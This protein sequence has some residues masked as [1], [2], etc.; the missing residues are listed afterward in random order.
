MGDPDDIGGIETVT[1]MPAVP[2]TP[3]FQDLLYSVKG[4]VA[5]I[6]MNR[7]HRRNALSGRLVNE[8]IVALEAAGADAGVG[9][10]VLQGAGGAF[11][12]GGDLSQMVG[13]G[14]DPLGDVPVRGGFVELNLAFTKVGKPIV[15]KVHRYAYGGGLGLVCAAH[16]AIAEDTAK[17]GTPEIDRG[18]FPMMIM[19]MI[20]RTVPRRRGLEMILT[21]ERIS[22]AEAVEIGLI[23]RAVPPEELDAA[24]LELATKLAS[25]PPAIVRLGLEAYH[26]QDDLDLAEALPYLQDM[27]MKCFGTDDAREGMTAFLEKRPPVWW[28][29]S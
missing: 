19:A 15:A 25:K 13:G 18:V 28:G 14:G 11:C 1:G 22:A 20:F 7:P 24:V 2:N 21:G 26:R 6:T 12:S 27:L 8:L 29:R 9:A 5:T 16:F 17:F 4:H 3:A 10:I 23:N